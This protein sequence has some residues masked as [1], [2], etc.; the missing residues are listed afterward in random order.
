MKIKLIVAAFMLLAVSCSNDE[1]L[2]SSVNLS[3]EQTL[4][5]VTVAVSGFEVSQEDFPGTRATAIGEVAEVKAITLAFYKSDG[6]QAYKHTQY[7]ESL[8]VGETFGAFSTTL[9][10]GN[11]TMVV[12][13]YNQG[14]IAQE[15]TLSSPTVATYGDDRVRETFAAT[16]AVSITNSD[17]VN[18]SATLNRIV[19]LLGVQSTDN[20]P[21]E[22]THI[23]MTFSAGGKGFSPTT[24]LAT[25]NTGFSNTLTLNNSVGTTSQN[26]SYLFLATDVQNMD[27][28][29][30][31]LDAADGNVL[32][33][34]TITNVSFRRNRVT[35]LTG[36]IYSGGNVSASSFQI[37][38]NWYNN[39]NINF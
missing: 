26:S 11:Y 9:P 1:S 27:V 20:R 4:A 15:V 23:R 17:A 31:T 8:E 39:L 3:S 29:I 16:Q 18:L 36:A 22:V 10:L 32:F 7:R 37:G 5:P 21:A 24:G 28:T 13:G 12:L 14:S 33:S 25:S 6:S 2:D 19:S 38:E 35:I 34:K 30:E